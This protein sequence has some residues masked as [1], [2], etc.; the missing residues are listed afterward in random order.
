MS[1]ALSSKVKPINSLLRSSLMEYLP[2]LRTFSS[3]PLS[4]NIFPFRKVILISASSGLDSIRASG[5]TMTT[6]A[7]LD[8]FVA[9]K[10]ELQLT[11]VSL[12]T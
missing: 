3:S 12:S 10:G 9:D 4:R 8:G 1:L 11:P 2:K 6:D 5:A 7:V